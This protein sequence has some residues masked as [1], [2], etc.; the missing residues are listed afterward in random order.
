MGNKV[1]SPTADGAGDGAGSGLFPKEILDNLTKKK[2]E[3]HGEERPNKSEEPAI[4][5]ENIYL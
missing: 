4:K 1:D 5:R 3:K 2:K